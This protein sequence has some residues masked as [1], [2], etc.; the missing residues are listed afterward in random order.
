MLPLLLDEWVPVLA[1]VEINDDP[2]APTTKT[3]KRLIAEQGDDAKIE[4]I[5]RGASFRRSACSV[6][7]AMVANTLPNSAARSSPTGWP[8]AELTLA[9]RT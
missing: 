2:I 4:W 3:G 1:G 7:R 5:H 8:A 9:P 6:N